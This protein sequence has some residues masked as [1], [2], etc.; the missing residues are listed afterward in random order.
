MNCDNCRHNCDC[1]KGCDPARYSQCQCTIEASPYDP[2]QWIM[3]CNG[4][5]HKI[6]IPKISETDTT[7]ST[8]YT[9]ATLNYKAERHRDVITGAQLGDIINVEDLRDTDIDASL[10][11]TCYEFIYHK[12]A[13][14]GEGCASVSDKWINFNINS[15]GAKQDYL[16]YIRGSNSYGCPVYL[17]TPTPNDQFHFAGWRQNGE[18]HEFGYYQAK[19]VDTLPKNASGDT[20]VLSQNMTTKEP[21]IGPLPFDCVLRNIMANLGSEVYGTFRVVQGTPGFG[22]VFNTVTGDFTISWDDWGDVAH[23]QHIGHGDLYGKANWTTDFNTKTGQLTWHVSS[24]TF[25]RVHWDKDLGT[26]SNIFLT[27]HGVQQPSGGHWVLLDR[28]HYTGDSSWNVP[29]N[30]NVPW[31]MNITNV[32]PGEYRTGFDFAY[33]LVDWAYEDDEGYQQINFHNKLKGWIIC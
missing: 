17:D 25:Y 3:A 23:T 12:Y 14:C 5:N 10:V 4:M 27:I 9:N 1:D 19:P 11:G 29:I 30:I 26:H 28:Y 15:P 13:D 33:F 21:I 2:T 7:L 6:R 24:I 18:H 8:N 16:Q 32:G 22:A 20:M 31:N